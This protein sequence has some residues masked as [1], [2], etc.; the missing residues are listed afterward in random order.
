MQRS[1]TLVRPGRRKAKEALLSTP[2]HVKGVSPAQRW[3][4]WTVYCSILTFC[5]PDALLS[6]LG[7]HTPNE[8]QAWREKV[9]LLGVITALC[10]AVGFITFGFS[11]VVC[12]ADTLP[13]IKASDIEN[14]SSGYLVIHGRAF[15]L[16][17]SAHP[18]AQGIPADTNVLYQPV[19]AAGLDASWLFQNVNRHCTGLITPATGSRILHRGSQLS[20]YAPCVLRHLNGSAVSGFFGSDSKSI[21]Y[22]GFNCHTTNNARN[23]YFGLKVAGEVF[24]NWHEIANRSRNL[25]VFRGDVL[26][27]DLLTAL[28]RNQVEY[29]AAFD[30]WRNGTR[31]SQLR[32][33]D[34][35][36][37][38]SSKTDV[39]LAMCLRDIARIGSVEGKT[40]GC[41]AS[42]VM[43]Y[44][45]LGMI[46]GLVGIKFLLAL[47]FQWVMAPKLGRLPKSR[48]AL[49]ERDLAIEAWSDNTQYQTKISSGDDQR[50]GMYTL[51]NA[52]SA[53]AT[54]LLRRTS[55]HRHPIDTRQ[56]EQGASYTICLVTA[57]SESAAGLRATLDSIACTTHPDKQKL[58]LVICDGLV[59][60]DGEDQTTAD[61]VLELMTR[62]EDEPE[63]H[64]YVAV[65]SGTKRHNRAKVY[66]GHYKC[67]DP[68]G[69]EY[70]VVPM[71]TI[72]KVGTADEAVNEPSRTGNRGKRDSQVLLMSFLQ[73][74]MFDER[75]SEL[76]YELFCAIREVCGKM[77]DVFESVLMVDADTVVFP[78]A[79]THMLHALK[80]DPLITGLCGETKISNKMASW[81]TIIQV[82]EYAISHHLSKS[83]ESVFGGVTCLPGCFSIY[84]VKAPAGSQDRWVP[85][86]ANPD[87]VEHYSETAV[88]TLHDKNL[89]LLGEDRYLSSLLLRTFPRRKMIF[90]PAAVCKTQV[91]DTFSVLLSQ[92]RRWINSTVHNLF[93]LVIVRDLCGT[94]CVSMNFV[95]FIELVGTLV[96][97]AAIGFTVYL[98]ISSIY[99]RPV[100]IIPLILLAI[101]LGLP[102]VLMVLT[103]KRFSYFLFMLAYLAALPIWNGIFPLYAFL[104]FD[105]F[106]WGETRKV[107]G[108]TGHGNA[109]GEKEGEFDSSMI[110]MKRWRDF[111]QDKAWQQH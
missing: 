42:Q 10:A 50:S 86:L 39:A 96:L 51:D 5:V 13:R 43:L 79:L 65:A 80:Q 15:N 38:L 7:K 9:G 34:T 110:V 84:R 109:H 75:L 106:S 103:M 70:H 16:L 98:L 107:Q 87:V 69:D 59:K 52:S 44:I 35:T 66:P 72:V 63:A 97:P 26:D 88:E 92:R 20:Q 90:L 18:A 46:L 3:T 27:L 41:L 28:D 73:K 76:D 14:E 100:P 11:A 47:Y 77:P 104:H 22:P 99:T 83:F 74:V 101:I 1:N 62:S 89:L 6:R 105:S 82:F 93:E 56:D 48:E 25:L 33:S 32:G 91:P 29:P 45:A 68:A 12:P 102:S 2:T 94:M 21:P 49:H 71:L 23:A 30:E 67:S 17:N 85:I 58:I 55:P 31:N 36:L 53:S 95:V 64:S 108:E 81:V 4:P 37:Q 8:R 60:G 111:Q 54:N 24:Y 61:L 40:V 78:D 19:S 57:Y